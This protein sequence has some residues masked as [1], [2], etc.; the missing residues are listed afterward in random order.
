MMKYAD[1]Q[2]LTFINACENCWTSSHPS[3][4]GKSW[5][6][7]IA[8]YPTSFIEKIGII[9]P[10]NFFRAED[11]E[12][13][14]RIEEGIN[15]Y[16]Y[17]TKIVNHN[18]LH[19]YLKPIN[20]NY[21]RFYFSIRN[22]LFRFAKNSKGKLKLFGVLFFYLRTALDKVLIEGDFGVFKAFC[23]AIWDFLTNTFS[24]QHN[25]KKI[26]AFFSPKPKARACPIHWA[27]KS[28]LSHQTQNLFSADFF[29]FLTGVDKEQLKY[30]SKLSHFFTQGVMISANTMILYP[31]FILAP[32]VLCINAFDLQTHKIQYI[33]M[34][35]SSL[36]GSMWRW[37]SS[38][39]TA[40]VSFLGMSIVIV[41]IGCKLLVKNR[42]IY[43]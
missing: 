6:V 22:Q 34:H 21:I 24:F 43:F 11:L 10:R 20:G 42:K 32:K 23:S 39:L 13:G 27:E 19:P 36:W 40:L 26:K 12:R 37:V 28:D 35:N 38:I 7:Q 41:V 8:G 30:S 5:W 29:L 17:Q 25:Q 16:H 33:Y 18:Y 1:A 14:E 3:D 2:T 15:K 31:L 9:D 4:K